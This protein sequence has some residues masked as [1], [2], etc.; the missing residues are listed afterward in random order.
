MKITLSAKAVVLALAA[1]LLT[2]ST[3]SASGA[4]KSFVIENANI[5][6]VE[7]GRILRNRSL[8]IDR[9]MITAIGMKE[10]VRPKTGDRVLDAAGK[11]LMPGLI[12]IHVHLDDT[13]DDL[14]LFLNYGVTTIRS[15]DGT[16]DHVGWKKAVAAGKLHGPTVFTSGPILYG[17]RGDFDGEI[18]SSTEDV[19]EA[20]RIIVNK[21]VET[22]YDAVKVYYQLSADQY[23]ALVAAAKKAGLPVVGHVPYA[24]T[25]A[26][27]MEAGQVTNEHMSGFDKEMVRPESKAANTR[28]AWGNMLRLT[29]IDDEKMAR[30]MKGMG[31]YKGKHWVT[32][33]VIIYDVFNRPDFVNSM[34][35]DEKMMGMLSPRK[36]E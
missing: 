5:V 1:I 17:S 20:A 11:Y 7:G 4:K 32:T 26:E 34:L 19:N 31:K 21:H 14:T 23:D 15:L 8:R 16:P 29:E 35:A 10:S 24:K 22:G 9:G 6:D 28:T 25:I 2:N 12:D 27:I 33:T 3:L 13:P 30:F 18:W 36:R